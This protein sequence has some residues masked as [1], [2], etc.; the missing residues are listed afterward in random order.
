[1][2]NYQSPVET[3]WEAGAAGQRLEVRGFGS[4]LASTGCRMLLKKCWAGL[5][6]DKHFNMW[7][8]ALPR[9]VWIP[10]LQACVS[11]KRRARRKARSGHSS[12]A[13]SA[14]SQLLAQ[15]KESLSCW[16]SF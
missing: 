13:S 16:F 11:A 8:S 3:P 6:R 15:P 14:A 1:M 12:P 5:L 4:V 2:G 7:K 10:S 9:A